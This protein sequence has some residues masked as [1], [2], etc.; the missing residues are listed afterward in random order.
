MYES[1]SIIFPILT[2]AHL[3]FFSWTISFAQHSLA[4]PST[5]SIS[6]AKSDKI[7]TSGY[8]I[9][10]RLELNVQILSSKNAI[11]QEWRKKLR[12]FI[13]H[14]TD[15][16]FHV[17][18]PKLSLKNNI[19]MPQSPLFEDGLKFSN[20]LNHK[21][22]GLFSYCMWLVEESQSL[23]SQFIFYLKHT[24]FSFTNFT[25]FFTIIFHFF[26]PYRYHFQHSKNIYLI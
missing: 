21:F 7:F 26:T 4:N 14:L 16:I 2:V 10:R 20:N 3:L 22:H 13:Y 12:D 15:T 17:I 18:I 9:I 19:R 8:W 1:L 6:I 25:H 11:Q 23:A 24:Y 5:F